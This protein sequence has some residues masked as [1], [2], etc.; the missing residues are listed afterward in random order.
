MPV[1][2]QGFADGR[3][4]GVGF[5]VFDHVGAEFLHA[6]RF[7]GST[8]AVQQSVGKGAVHARFA[9]GHD[10]F[11]AG[12]EAPARGVSLVALRH[13][14][15]AAGEERAGETGIRDQKSMVAVDPADKAADG[16]VGDVFVEGALVGVHRY[17]VPLVENRVELPVSGVVDDQVIVGGNA[18]DQLPERCKNAGF[19]GFLVKDRHHMRLIETVSFDHQLDESPGIAHRIE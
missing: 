8:Q 16:I 5:N 14:F 13:I 18:L 1:Y 12:G 3:L 2:F 7:A 4:E 6:E 19:C 10:L 15:G 11:A 9:V 17:P